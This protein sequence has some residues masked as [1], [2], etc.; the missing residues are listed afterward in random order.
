[1]KE[2]NLKKKTL[3]GKEGNSA[4]TN[5]E[6]TGSEAEG[7]TSE[8]RNAEH[9]K[10]ASDSHK[11]N[12]RKKNKNK[13]KV[14]KT[15]II[16]A[17]VIFAAAAVSYS[18]FGFVVYNNKF[19]P[20]TTVD[21]ISCEGMNSADLVKEL[22][23]KI[24]E[25]S[26]DIKKDGQIVDSIRSEEV[27]AALA[28]DIDN[29][30]SS[31][32]DSQNKLMWGIGYIKKPENIAL[33]GYV[34]IDDD[35]FESF[36]KESEG[37]NLPTTVENK[38]Q[39]V[40]FIDGRF[41]VGDP[42]YGDEINKDSYM[43][44][45]KENILALNKEMELNDYDCYTKPSKIEDIES[46]NEACEKANSMLNYGGFSIKC[47]GIKS[48]LAKEIAEASVVID[49]NF[50]VTFNQETISNAVAKVASKYNTAGITRKFKTSHGTIVNVE[51]GD[52]GCRF[53][54]KNLAD[55]AQK[56][57][58]KGEKI[59]L[60]LEYTQ[61]VLDPNVEGIGNTYV[62]VDLTNQYAFVYINGK[63][64]VET[65]VVTGLAGTSRATPQGTYMLKNKLKN[66]TLVGPNYRTPVSYW[67]PFNGGIGLHDATWQPRFGGELYRTRGSH[68]CVNLPL[69]KA[70][71][72][73]NAVIVKMPVVCYYHERLSNF[74]STNSSGMPTG[75]TTMAVS[76][77]TGDS[78][79]TASQVVAEAIKKNNTTNNK[80]VNNTYNNKKNKTTNTN[81]TNTNTTNTNEN[82]TIIDENGNVISENVIKE[83]VITPSAIE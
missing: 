72:I 38:N 46:F 15:L 78:N 4:G 45:V 47:D 17:V 48:D 24:E 2:Q 43:S 19:L 64:T 56:A 81:T 35:V 76:G 27:N 52:Y 18:V 74:Q 73:Y 41:K 65:A 16:A 23:S 7:Y 26:L 59:N 13:R 28:K 49:D 58:L 57:F 67:M 10:T 32:I 53:S 39:S 68:G 82:N 20:R 1:M 5:R 69:K 22:S 3:K 51:G 79:G 80:S 66:V 60:T 50:N 36:I 14:L 77:S 54:T 70:G 33:D 40:E 71:E 31:I 21:G 25:Y 42:I 12:G 34:T 83:Q 11:N 37:Y 8:S 75:V 6:R 44:K 63:L 9:L 29:R 55:N 61:N 62:E 30:V